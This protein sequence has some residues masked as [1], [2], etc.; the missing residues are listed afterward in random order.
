ML[1]RY[2]WNFGLFHTKQR[3]F[4]NC[5]LL[6]NSTTLLPLSGSP[7]YSAHVP[8]LL[9][10]KHMSLFY[11]HLQICNLIMK[12]LNFKYDFPARIC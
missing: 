7:L 4:I 3:N 5:M 12:F 6:M 1:D 10:E 8:L 2:N 11:L 9:L